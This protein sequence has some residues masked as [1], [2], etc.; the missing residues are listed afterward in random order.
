MPRVNQTHN[1][2]IHQW[3]GNILQVKLPL[4][5]PLQARLTQCLFSTATDVIGFPV[6]GP[7]FVSKLF[8][9]THTMDPTLSPRSGQVTCSSIEIF[10]NA[11]RPS[12]KS[13]HQKIKIQFVNT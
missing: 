11:V 7:C 12:T 5:L 8:D 13:L 10:R 6:P 4:L 9:T 3:K 1:L 2:P